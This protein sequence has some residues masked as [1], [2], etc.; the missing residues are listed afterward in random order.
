MPARLGWIGVV[1]AR[2]LSDRIR[3]FAPYSRPSAELV[4]L[5]M[6]TEE[7]DVI[8]APR[9]SSVDWAGRRVSGLRVS[10][11]ALHFTTSASGRTHRA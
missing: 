10:S 7:P 9:P 5:L 11:S 1:E 6:E 3:L 8:L 4:Q 2:A